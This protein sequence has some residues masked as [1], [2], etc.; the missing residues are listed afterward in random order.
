MKLVVIGSSNIDLVIRLPRIPSPGETILG[1]ESEQFFGGKG[2]NQAVAAH[3]AGAEV[4]FITKL[5]QDTF[6]NDY[7]A[8]LSKAGL[9]EKY[10]LRDLKKP[11]GQA[12]IWVD[13][14]GENAIAVASG[15]N[16]SLSQTDLQNFSKE[17]MKADYVLIQPETPIPSILHL[18]KMLEGSETKLILN[19]APGIA[20]PG[21]VLEKIWLITPNEHEAFVL[22]GQKITDLHTAAKAAK[23][24][25]KSGPQNVL[26]TMGAEGALLCTANSTKHFPAQKVDPTDTTAAGDVF[27]GYL[28]AMLSQNLS[29]EESIQIAGKAAAISVTRAG[30]QASIPYLSEIEVL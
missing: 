2:A 4:G 24:L 29:L 21:S 3:K 15:A 25:L 14:N 10:I 5:G 6:G 1:G 20:L 12:Q 11:T 17:I 19:P 27:N 22:T 28:A 30:A 13:E 23:T 18:C 7:A 9:P 8:Y 16:A 26:I